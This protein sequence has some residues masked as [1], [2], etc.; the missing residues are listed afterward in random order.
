MLVEKRTK[1][2]I[3]VMK[4][5]SI[6]TSVGFLALALYYWFVPIPKGSDNFAG[7]M[8]M[9]SAI[10]CGVVSIVFM[11]IAI[12]FNKILQKPKTNTILLVFCS[13]LGIWGIGYLISTLFILF[14]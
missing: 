6:I 7:M 4:W 5:L 11:P 10:F 12:Y 8:A 13:L 14:L 2:F 1:K 3:Q 9:I